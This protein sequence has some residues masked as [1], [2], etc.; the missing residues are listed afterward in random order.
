MTEEIGHKLTRRHL[1]GAAG[2]GVVGM[3]ALSSIALAQGVDEMAKP[4][5]MQ[6]CKDAVTSSCA[7]TATARNPDSTE[8]SRMPVFAKEALAGPPYVDPR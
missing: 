7:I 8:P 1:V 4:T 6:F 5:E 2:A 3:S